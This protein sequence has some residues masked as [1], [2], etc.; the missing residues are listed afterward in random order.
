MF[1]CARTNTWARGP[2]ALLIQH[3]CPMRHIVTS[4]EAPLPP[5][6]LSTCFI[7]STIFEKKKNVTEHEMCVL[8]FSTKLI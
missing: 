3:A 4:F 7:N 1:V 6:F 2:V 8:I 5:P